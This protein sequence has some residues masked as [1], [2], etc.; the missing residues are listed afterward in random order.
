MS[1]YVRA[2]KRATKQAM[3]PVARLVVGDASDLPIELWG[4]RLRSDGRLL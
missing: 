4:M 2:F 1:G 3:V